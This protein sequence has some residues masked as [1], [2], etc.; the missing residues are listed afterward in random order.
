M[1]KL[2]CFLFSIIVAIIIVAIAIMYGISYAEIG[3]PTKTPEQHKAFECPK[4]HISDQNKCFTCHVT[5]SF[6][7]KETL[8]NA[9]FDYPNNRTSLE[10]LPNGKIGHFYMDDIADEQFRQT[11][12]YFY[13]HKVNRM[14][15]EIHSPG[16]S[17]FD[18]WRI[19]GMTDEAIG[20]GI[21]IETRVYG[22]AASAGFLIFLTGQ[23]R[24]VSENAELM[25]HELKVGKFLS[26]ESPSDQEDESKIMRHLQ[27]TCNKWIAGKSKMTKEELDSKIRKKEFWINGKEALDMG[28]AT[29]LIK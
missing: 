17:L 7:I 11:L 23:D 26:F 5:P 22:F 3:E 19:K 4:T 18:A 25:W 16:G 29:K 24:V 2:D 1:K 8:P 27:D 15:I 12:K 14:I 13:H 6:K 20:N 28:F 9:E 21:K 10:C